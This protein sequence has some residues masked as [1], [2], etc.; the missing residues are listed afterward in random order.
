MRR[1]I[2]ISAGGYK[3]RK[4]PLLA[5]RVE[6]MRKDAKRDKFHEIT[7]NVM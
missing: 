1:L 3:V 2:W 5:K 4:E 6:K 7:C